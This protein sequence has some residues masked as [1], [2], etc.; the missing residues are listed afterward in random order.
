MKAVRIHEHGGPEVLRYEEVPDPAVPPGEVL[1]RVRAC[2]MNHLDLWLRRGLPGRP[3][4][5]PRIV[6]SDMAGEIVRVD[7]RVSKVAP[8]DRVLIAP[9]HSC[10]P[11]PGLPAGPRQPLPPIL[12]LGIV[13]DG[14]YAEL[15]AAPEVTRSQSLT[16]SRLTK[17]R[18][19][20]W[21]FSLPGIC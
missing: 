4:S 12:D 3:M 2:A 6:G 11:L 7:E 21:C 5:L 9:G 17:P 16:G 14:G 20:P 1:V 13:R 18:P 10:G 15:V 8:S 19:S